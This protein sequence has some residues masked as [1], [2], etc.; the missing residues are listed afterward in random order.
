MMVTAMVND[1]RRRL[2][3]LVCVFPFGLK[4]R[5]SQRSALSWWIKEAV[6][7]ED[8]T[9]GIASAGLDLGNRSADY[10]TMAVVLHRPADLCNKQ[11][12]D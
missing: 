1:G 2:K 12:S 11:E 7:L 5:S 9:E 8:S 4:T 10:L 3:P 6:D